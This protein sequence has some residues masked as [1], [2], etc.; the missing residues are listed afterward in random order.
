MRGDIAVSDGVGIPPTTDWVCVNHPKPLAYP[1]VRLSQN[2]IRWVKDRAID[3]VSYT[4]LA[5]HPY[6]RDSNPPTSALKQ[7]VKN[8]SLSTLHP[9]GQALVNSIIRVCKEAFSDKLYL[10][11]PS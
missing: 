11:L 7:I 8:P 1:T 5:R 6:N 2:V 4:R 10:L 9:R 3:L